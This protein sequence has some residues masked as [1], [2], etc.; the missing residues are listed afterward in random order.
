MLEGEVSSRLTLV[1]EVKAAEN[2]TGRM[3]VKRSVFVL[4]IFMKNS[5]LKIYVFIS[6]L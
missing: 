1:H 5:F 4:G 3:P 2:V 6:I